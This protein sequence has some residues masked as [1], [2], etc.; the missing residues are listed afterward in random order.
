MKLLAP[1][2]PLIGEVQLPIS[3]SIANRNLIIA[4]LAKKT[5]LLPHQLPE[6]VRV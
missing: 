6:D 4:A 2:G 5:I 3:K 1:Q